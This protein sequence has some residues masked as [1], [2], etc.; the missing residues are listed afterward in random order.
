MVDPVGIAP[1][2]YIAVSHLVDDDLFP[3]N[4]ESDDKK[5]LVLPG[6]IEKGPQAISFDI[7]EHAAAEPH[8]GRPQQYALGGDTVV[9]AEVFREGRVPEDDDVGGGSF[10]FFGA[11]PVLEIACPGKAREYGGV[12]TGVMDRITLKAVCSPQR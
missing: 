6:Y 7:A 2:L 8:L 4:S 12:L 9:A 10:T 5:D 11:R 3:G 1:V